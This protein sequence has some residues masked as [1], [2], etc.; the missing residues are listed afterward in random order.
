MTPYAEITPAE[1]KA[2]LDTGVAVDLLDVREQWEHAL[3]ALP[4][5]RL[6]PIDELPGRL[7]ELDPGHE[8]VVYCHHGVRSAA[9]AEWLRRQAIPAVNLQGGIDA[10]AVEVDP[11]LPRY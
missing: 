9:A 3:V 1:L 5:A 11:G 6:I 10:W 2:R 4:S 7:G 8:V